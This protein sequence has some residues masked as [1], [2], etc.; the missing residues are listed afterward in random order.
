MPSPFVFVA[1]DIC[2]IRIFQLCNYF[3]PTY[4]PANTQPFFSTCGPAPLSPTQTTV[5]VPSTSPHFPF[6][7]PTAS[8]LLPPNSPSDPNMA[9][10]W[11]PPQPVPGSM[12]HQRRTSIARHPAGVPSSSIPAYF[13]NPP[14]SSHPRRSHNPFPGG[15]KTAHETGQATVFNFLVM[16]FPYTVSCLFGS[17]LLVPPTLTYACS[18]QSY[19]VLLFWLSNGWYKQYNA[20]PNGTSLLASPLLELRT[21]LSFRN[22]VLKLRVIVRHTTSCGPKEVDL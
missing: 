15:K 2:N 14:A 19:M 10:R 12:D 8:I 7:Q 3:H 4:P 13:S 5:R 20:S 18:I 17:L 22:Y 11:A 1:K 21:P 6:S 16:I 9:R